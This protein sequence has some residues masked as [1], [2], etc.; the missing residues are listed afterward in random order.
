MLSISKLFQKQWTY[1]KV[2]YTINP[3]CIEI[4][5]IHVRVLMQY[6]RYL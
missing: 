5:E 3:L 6:I 4:L 1:Y 2:V